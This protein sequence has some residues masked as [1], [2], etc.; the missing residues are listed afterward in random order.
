MQS[1]RIQTQEGEIRFMVF[2]GARVRGLFWGEMGTQK[3]KQSR[4]RCGVKFLFK[5]LEDDE[6]K[7]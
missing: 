4:T 3:E 1:K 2:V 7:N 5:F 6:M